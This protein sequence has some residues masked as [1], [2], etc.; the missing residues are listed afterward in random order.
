MGAMGVLELLRPLARRPRERCGPA[1]AEL[2][3]L[4]GI[5]SDDLRPAGTN[6]DCLILAALLK[7]APRSLGIL[8]LFLDGIIDDGW[9]LDVVTKLPQANQASERRLHAQLKRVIRPLR[10]GEIRSARLR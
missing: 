3:R 8:A 10:G 7:L 4:D 2:P 6:L 1:F 5:L 9:R